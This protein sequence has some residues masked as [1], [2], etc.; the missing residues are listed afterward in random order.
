MT[1]FM[2]PAEPGDV[3]HQ[4]IGLIPPPIWLLIPK[5]QLDG[6]LTSGPDCVAV[7]EI[8]GAF[9][10]CVLAIW[11]KRAIVKWVRKPTEEKGDERDK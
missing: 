3:M 7:L 1:L 9:F 4:I 2:R 10:L 8:C 5:K 11:I 6:S